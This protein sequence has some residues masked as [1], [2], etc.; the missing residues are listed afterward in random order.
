MEDYSDMRK[1]PVPALRQLE[2]PYSRRQRLAFKQGSLA[3]HWKSLYPDLFDQDDARLAATQPT[4]HFYE[5]LAAILLFHST[6]YLSL[7]EKYQFELHARKRTVMA[8]LKSSSLDCALSSLKRYGRAQA[9]DLLVYS[10]RRKDWFF[11][12]VKGESDRLD[13]KQLRHF[14]DLVEVTG[15]PILLVKFLPI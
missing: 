15:R 12:E 9:P 3:R 2:F 14:E 8:D 1:P 7:I 5:W 10:K 11:T 13:S 4:H 6:G